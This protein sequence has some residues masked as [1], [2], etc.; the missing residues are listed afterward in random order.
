MSRFEIQRTDDGSLT[1]YDILFKETFHSK[2]GARCESEYVFIEQGLKKFCNFP[3][4]KIL[5]IGFGTGFNAFLTFLKK[6][7]DQ[8]I[9]YE[10]IELFPIE[11]EQIASIAESLSEK[12]LYQN[13]TAAKWNEEQRISSD[14][15]LYK[16]NE[17]VAKVIFDKQFDLVYFDAFSP[18]TQP[19]LWTLD[20]FRNIYQ[21][22]RV[23]GVLV[24]YASSGIAKQ[25]L[26]NTGFIVE[27]LPGPP[28]KHHML[29]AKKIS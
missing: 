28:H 22:L 15:I 6:P 2:F 14:F 18:K 12:E 1:I 13:L 7:Q 24:T 26:R 27:R 17:D 5:E 8:K 23:G 11:E 19:E 20:I 3:D 21:H 25:N 29:R 9:F 10:A 4:L 16:R